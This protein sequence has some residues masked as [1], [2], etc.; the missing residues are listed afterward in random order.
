MTKKQVMI[1]IQEKLVK[2]HTYNFEANKLYGK[3]IAKELFK[4]DLEF[5][6]T[7][8]SLIGPVTD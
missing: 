3:E 1:R 8:I 5:Y 6:T 4:T 7:L 2:L